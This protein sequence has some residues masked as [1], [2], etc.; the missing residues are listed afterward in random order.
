ME[1]SLHT[2]SE[3]AQLTLA[4]GLLMACGAN[5]MLVWAFL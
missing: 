4:V 3:R 5:V 1:N 2:F